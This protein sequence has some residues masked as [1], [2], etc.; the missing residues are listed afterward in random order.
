MKT[1]RSLVLLAVFASLAL[2]GC[3]GPHPIRDRWCES[4]GHPPSSY[5]PAYAQY[6]QYQQPACAC[7]QPVR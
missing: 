4:W 3:C 6:P 7:P 2:A 5:Q 1:I